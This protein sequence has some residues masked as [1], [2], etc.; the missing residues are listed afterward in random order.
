MLG[1]S[2]VAELL[3]ASQGLKTFICIVTCIPIAK[4][5]LR[6]QAS[7]IKILFSMGSEPQPLLCNV[8]KQPS[9]TETV[10]SA[11]SVPRRYLEDNR[12][13]KAVEDSVVE[14]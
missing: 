9:T 3:A 7:T 10:F 11:W 6:K 4:Q 14:C 13:Y 12:H 1:N 8:G 5:R 2:S